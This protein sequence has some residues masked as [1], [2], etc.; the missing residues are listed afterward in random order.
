MWRVHG[1]CLCKPEAGPLEGVL[2]SAHFVLVFVLVVGGGRGVWG[3][4]FAAGC[5]R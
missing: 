4:C 1:A 2:P 3:Q 5:P